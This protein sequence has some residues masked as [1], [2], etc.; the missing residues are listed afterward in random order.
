MENCITHNTTKSVKM[1]EKV[2]QKKNGVKMAEKLFQ[3]L[4][5]KT[6]MGTKKEREI[7]FSKP[8]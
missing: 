6:R 1:A 3:K 5:S 8:F 7:T 2:F 4:I